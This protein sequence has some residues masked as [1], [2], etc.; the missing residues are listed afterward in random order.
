MPKDTLINCP[1][2]AERFGIALGAAQLGIHHKFY[3][4]LVMH[5]LNESKPF[6]KE[7]KDYSF[8]IEGWRV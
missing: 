4:P 2:I 1:W 7:G 3:D 6:N 8:V 5:P